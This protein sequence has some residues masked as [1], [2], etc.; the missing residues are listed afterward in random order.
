MVMMVMCGMV[1]M[2]MSGMVTTVIYC[3]VDPVSLANDWPSAQKACNNISTHCQRW[4]ASC[5]RR[6]HGTSIINIK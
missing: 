3:M 1:K 2:V 6:F 5:A 4:L